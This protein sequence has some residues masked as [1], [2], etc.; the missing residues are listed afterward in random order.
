M[1][2]GRSASR[3]PRPSGDFCRRF[4]EAAIE[5]LQT[6]INET[7]VQVWRTQ[8]ATFFAEAVI[9]ADQPMTTIERRGQRNIVPTGEARAAI[10]WRLTSSAEP[11]TRLFWD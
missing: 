3:T 1:R 10:A 5:A 4:D 6:A 11:Q 9:D 8:P 7:R 2:W